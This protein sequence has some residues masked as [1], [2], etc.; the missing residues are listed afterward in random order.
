MPQRWL[1]VVGL[2]A[3]VVGGGAEDGSLDAHVGGAAPRPSLASGMPLFSRKS[4]KVS[5]RARIVSLDV[6]NHLGGAVSNVGFQHA[7]ERE[8][9]RNHETKTAVFKVRITPPG[10]GPDVESETGKVTGDGAHITQI[11]MNR[12][13]AETYVLYDPA[14]P[15]HC[16]IDT[17]RLESEFGPLQRPPG[18]ATR[19]AMP[20]ARQPDVAPASASSA[21][22]ATIAAQAGTAAP[23]GA[24]EADELVKLA[25]LHS[26][27]ALTDEEFSAAK[28]R[29]LGTG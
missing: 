19:L 28:Q 2:A 21:L 8:I 4:E 14:R 17:E 3:S 1:G 27:G 5:A 20:S 22:A 13:A 7:S 18:T 26:A 29:I 10:G 9:A 12:G 23:A 16:E 24:S 6:Y 11:N 25:A 15:K